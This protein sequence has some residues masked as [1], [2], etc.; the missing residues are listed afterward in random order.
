MTKTWNV[1]LPVGCN[2]SNHPVSETSTAFESPQKEL[3]LQSSSALLSKHCCRQAPLPH[4]HCHRGCLL[5][6]L[7]LEQVSGYPNFKRTMWSHCAGK[8]MVCFADKVKELQKCPQELEKA[9]QCK[10][11]WRED[12]SALPGRRPCSL[13]QLAMWK[14]LHETESSM[15]R[16][17]AGRLCEQLARETDRNGWEAEVP[18]AVGSGIDTEILTHGR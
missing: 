13:W 9:C 2:K 18:N 11:Q 12:T 17:S 4:C 3:A 16:V 1:R 8:E 7:H 5:R 15:G 10:G 14:C 6:V